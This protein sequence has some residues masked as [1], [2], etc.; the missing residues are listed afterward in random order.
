MHAKETVD[1]ESTRYALTHIQFSGSKG[2][3]ATTDGHQVLFQSGFQFPWADDVLV[4]APAILGCSE[5]AQD[6]SIG[7]GRTDD[8]VARRLGSLPPGIWTILLR[9]DKEGKFPAGSTACCPLPTR[10]SRDCC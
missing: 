2:Q 6:H 5:L 8:C 3:I 10:S 1:H 4:P 7:V 9:I